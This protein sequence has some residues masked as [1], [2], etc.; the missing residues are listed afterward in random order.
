M[1]LIL[2]GIKKRV[3]TIEAQ[4]LPTEV[5]LLAETEAGTT[6]EVTVEEWFNRRHELRFRKFTRGFDPTYHDIDLLIS[7]MFEECGMMEEAERW[8]AK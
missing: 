8:A 3:G 7:A 4:V 2:N 6:T 5:W 1:G